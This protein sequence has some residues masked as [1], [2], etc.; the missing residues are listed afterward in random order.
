MRHRVVVIATLCQ[1]FSIKQY[2][3]MF[4]CMY[5]CMYVC[6]YV[7]MYAYIC[8]TKQYVCIILSV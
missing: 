4:V 8:I 2:L 3:Y 6:M 7:C 5:A 1:S